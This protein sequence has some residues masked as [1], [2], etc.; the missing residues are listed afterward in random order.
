MNPTS[1]IP[2]TNLKGQVKTLMSSGKL[3]IQLKYLEQI[4]WQD[5][6]F[7]K[8]L[9]CQN[10]PQNMEKNRFQEIIPGNIKKKQTQSM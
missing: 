2:C 1:T 7:E 5:N 10:L 4:S 9:K 3:E 8:P 6:V